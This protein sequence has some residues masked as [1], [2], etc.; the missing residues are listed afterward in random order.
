VAE[1]AETEDQQHDLTITEQD[2]QTLLQAKAAV[3]SAIRLLIQRAGT[4][5]S[6]LR[7]IY[8]AGGFGRYINV[9]NAITIGLLPEI[10]PS[11]YV[12]IGNGSLAGAFL[13]LVDRNSWQGF[14]EVMT[15]PE[16]IE[17]NMDAAFQ[18]E[19]TFALFLPNFQKELFPKTAQA[20]EA[21]G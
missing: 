8:L 13:A 7:R 9:E 10:D 6:A 3:F 18:D 19:Y 11:N 4:T 17:L 20:L 2:I 14:R 5:V 16:V 21:V 15:K 12:A 1:G